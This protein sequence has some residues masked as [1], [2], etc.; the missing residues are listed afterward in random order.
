MS[1]SSI[2]RVAETDERTIEYLSTIDSTTSANYIEKL[3]NTPI[4]GQNRV[5]KK[6]GVQEENFRNLYWNF[7]ELSF[8][9][10]LRIEDKTKEKRLLFLPKV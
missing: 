5:V 2:R 9:L 8:F 6:I 3:I 10:S 4:K 1:L 7:T